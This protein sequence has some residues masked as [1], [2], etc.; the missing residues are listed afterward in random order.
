MP[1]CGLSCIPILIQMPSR[2]L[3]QNENWRNNHIFSIYEIKHQKED[4]IK[5]QRQY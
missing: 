1:Y 5:M 4:N 2:N 3:Y